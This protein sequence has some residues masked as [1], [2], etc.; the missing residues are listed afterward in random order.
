[1]NDP[2]RTEALQLYRWMRT[3]RRIDD[4]EREFV[5]RGEAFFQV[6]GAGHEA[7]AALALVLKPEDYL[8]CHYRDK[9]LMLARGIP[10]LEFFDS[11]LCTGASHSAGRQMS[12]HLSA[13]ALKI[14]SVVGPVGNSALQ[15][16]G[17][18]QQIKDQPSRPIVLCSLGDG[19]TQQGEVMESIAEVV[20]STLPVL[21]LIEDNH[22]SISTP[23]GGKTFFSLPDGDAKSFY[24]LAVHRV[25]GTDP[26]ACLS[27][28]RTLVK[29]MRKSRA[30]VLCVMQVERLTSH[31]N[32]DDDTVYRDPE[33]VQRL[34][35]TADPIAKL[36]EHLRASGCAEGGLTVLDQQIRA[37]VRAAAEKA[38]DHPAPSAES[39]AKAAVPSKLTNRHLEYRGSTHPEP[40]TMAEALRETLRSQMTT[41]ERVTLY[42][43]DIEDPKGDVFGVTRGLTAAFPGRVRNSPLSESTIVGTSIGRAFAGGR[44]VAF[45]QFA[46]FLPLAFN[47]LAMELA[48][49]HWRTQGSWPAPVILM[50][51]CGAYRPGLGPFHAH[52]FESIVAHLPGID[53]VVS[54]TAADA[55]GMLNAAFASQRPT[56]IFYPKALL[57]DRSR[58]TSP[59]VGKQF[60]PIGAARVVRTGQELTLV[61]WGNTVPICEKVAA[62]LESAGVS[63]EVIDLRW[64]SPWDRETVCESVRKTRRLLVVHEDNLSVGFGAEI[65]AALSESVEGL[66]KCRRVARPDT[67]I[68]CHFGNQLD[69]LPSYQTVLAA[70]AEMIDL[71]LSWTLPAPP[72]AGRQ[73]V[74]A[75]GS[76]PS[77]QNVDV[78]EISVRVGDAVKAGQ[79]IASLEADKAI[80]D[81]ASPADGIVEAIHLQVGDKAPVDAPLMTLLVARGRPRQPNS[82]VHGVARLAR[83]VSKRALGSG[84]PS[85]TNVMLTGLAACRGRA[86]LDN[87]E[88]ALRFPALAASNGGGDGIFERTGIESRLVADPDQDAVTMAMEAANAAL[89]E[90]GV[91]ARDL[92]LVICSTSTPVMISPS[93]ACQVLH[94]LAP[95]SDIPAYDLQAACSGYLY[96]LANAWD[97]VQQRPTATVLVLTTETMRRIVDID[98]PGTSTIFADAATATI[99]SSGLT[100][101]PALASLQRPV[102]GARGEN[103][104]TLR[105]PFPGTGAHVHMDGGRIF[106]EA[107]RSMAEM[108]S[109]ACSQS[110]ISL[111][112]L[113]LVVPHQANGRIIE[114]LRTRL[115]LAE[116]QVWNE[117]RFQGNTSS[118]SIPLALDTV[119]RHDVSTQRIGLCAFGAGYTFGGAILELG[120]PR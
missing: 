29:D 61:G 102:L 72:D 59:D 117:I 20:R 17:I 79:T 80:V 89:K 120:G 68:P 64:I 95:G 25:D 53:V 2:C 27:T 60:I 1:M 107:I 62:T 82:E 75:I 113:D 85:R 54:S 44:P 26:V 105:V 47:Q 71:D 16:A 48:S 8:H 118:S 93:T 14:L 10:M 92:S 119:L 37:E 18:A 91:E 42:G 4:M 50:V 30:P 32:A 70:A 56:I 97:F 104:K 58:A 40:I 101:G 103:G 115:S 45:L 12:A 23:T 106:V 35:E 114:A 69:L 43:E 3:A 81:L 51:T 116:S 88:L 13:P 7:S 87:Q 99:I 55:A 49:V 86:K 34:R 65:L 52:S 83:R 5:A 96:A 41:D 31:T 46:D 15:A 84:P 78:V 33:E 110:G 109:Q 112:D 98:D 73:V 9:A 24:G 74:T 77:D 108:L 67:F 39:T 11:L 6:S 94:S 28:F 100:R 66:L 38:L 19:M 111:H 76:S 63:A 36:R 21:F 22:F 90:A 57:S